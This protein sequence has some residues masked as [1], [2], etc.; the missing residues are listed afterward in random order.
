MNLALMIIAMI[1]LL[2]VEFFYLRHI[3]GRFL[4]YWRF[5]ITKR[6]TAYIKYSIITVIMGISLILLTVPGMIVIHFIIASLV[7]ELFGLL[8]KV[9]SRRDFKV[10]KFISTSLAVP[11]VI[12]V[13][14]VIYGYFNAHNV[15][16]TEYTVTTEKALGRDYKIAFLSD[17]HMGV[18]LD[19]DEIKEMCDEI[20]SFSPDMLLLG[21]DLVDESTT[22]EEMQKLFELLGNVK[23]TYGVYFAFGNHDAPRNQ[24]MN[25]SEFT[26]KELLD[27]MGANG[28]VVLQDQWVNL[29]D[30]LVLIG[31]RDAYFRGNDQIDEREDIETLMGAVDKN[32]Y[33]ILLEHQPREYERNKNAGVNLMLSGHTHAGQIWPCGWL[34]QLLAPNEQNYGMETDEDFCGIVSSGVAG[35]SFPVKTEKHAEFLIVTLTEK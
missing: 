22:K 33:S 24:E 34:T 15:V 21:G 2:V 9:I 32:R 1:V 23:T 14:M 4:V 28:I 30:D 10:V 35:W 8:V 29:G 5:D 7:F 31:H 18:S 16:A 3:I 20:S 12:S 26:E 13:S 11:L 19:F 6:K 27:T 17:V 25:E